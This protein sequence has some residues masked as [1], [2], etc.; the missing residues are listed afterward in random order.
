MGLFRR[1]DTDLFSIPEQGGVPVPEPM[2]SDFRL[3]VEDVFF[4]RRRGLVVTGTIEAGTVEV[5]SVVTV[6][7]A[8][9]AAVNVAVAGVERARKLPTRAVAGEAVGLLLK[10]LTP[11]DIARGDVVRAAR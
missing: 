4:I 7:R 11:D 5:G 10:E 3:V 6:E 2:A 1:R 8:G 9:K